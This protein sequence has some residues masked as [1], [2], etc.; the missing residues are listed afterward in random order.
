MTPQDYFQRRQKSASDIFK[1]RQPTPKQYRS[2]NSTT[3]RREK[4]CFHFGVNCPFNVNLILRYL[5]FSNKFSFSWI[6]L[7]TSPSLYSGLVTLLSC[8][9]DFALRTINSKQWTQLV[10]IS[11]MHNLMSPSFFFCFVIYCCYLSEFMKLL[12]MLIFKLF[13]FAHNFFFLKF[14]HLCLGLKGSTFF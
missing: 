13:S 7:K 1:T 14:C 5:L 3:G 9:V 4:M 11:D 6:A 8:L 2:I 12:C 10:F